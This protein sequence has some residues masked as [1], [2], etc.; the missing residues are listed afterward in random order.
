M[1]NIVMMTLLLF[2]TEAWAERTRPVPVSTDFVG[3]FEMPGE[4]DDARP[5]DGKDC[6]RSGWGGGNQTSKMRIESTTVTFKAGK[7]L[8]HTSTCSIQAFEETEDHSDSVGYLMRLTCRGSSGEPFKLS[9]I[10]TL[11][12]IAGLPVLTVTDTKRLTTEIYLQ[13]TAR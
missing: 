11:H 5:F 2:A 7:G 8:S 12:S 3:Y 9:Q 4:G 6:S 10:W 1:R 13:C